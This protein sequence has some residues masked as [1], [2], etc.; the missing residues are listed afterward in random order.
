MG[1]MHEGTALLD[2]GR[3]LALRNGLPLTALRASVNMAVYL[4]SSD[5]R[6]ALE[7]QRAAVEIATRLGM[8]TAAILMRAAR[9]ETGLRTASIAGAAEEIDAALAE[10][11]E[12][13]DRAQLLPVAVKVRAALGLDIGDHLT[14]LERV[15]A[16]IGDPQVRGASL[17]ARG[18]AAFAAGRMKEAYDSWRETARLADSWPFVL[19]QAARAALWSRELDDGRSALGALDETGAHGPALEASRATIQA[20]IAALEGRAVEAVSLYREAL[21]QWRELGLPFDAALTTIDM[22]LLLSPVQQEVQAAVPQ[23]RET[24]TA[25]GSRPF[26][27]HL[28][29][30]LATEIRPVPA[31]TS[32]SR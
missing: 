23:A 12:P 10:E 15:T 3:Q 18:F 6:A 1:R 7:M 22:A 32:Y 28:E 31:V 29:R 17:D 26:L 19:A 11:L 8:R 27:E 24:L 30:A 4:D 2:A 21:D 13:T 14:E 5:P 9:L 16:L 25:M 20:G